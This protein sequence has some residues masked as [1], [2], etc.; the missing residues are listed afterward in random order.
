MKIIIGTRGSQLAL[1]QANYTKDIL[2][3][4]GLE[5]EIK[6]ISTEGDRSQEWN[7]RFDKLDGKGFFTKELEDALIGEQVDL[8]V[9]SFKDLPTEM[10]ANL[11]IGG[12]SHRANPSET[13]LIR[14]EFYDEKQVLKI[15]H[16]AIIGTSSARRKSQLMAYRPDLIIKDLRGNVPTRIKKLLEGEYDAILLAA[17]GLERLKPDIG[18]LMRFTL[19]PSEFIPAAAQGA[20]A[21]QC[22]KEHKE[23][24][25]HLNEMSH[26]ETRAEVEMERDILSAFGGGCQEPLGIYCKGDSDADDKRIFK[27]FISKAETWNAAPLQLYF[28]TYHLEDFARQIAESVRGIK[29]Q[30]VFIS[31]SFRE[32][33]YLPRSLEHLGFLFVASSLIEF[34]QIDIKVVPVSDWIFFTSKH[35]VKYFLKQ[36][37]KLWDVKFGCISKQTAFAL[38][39]F[40][41]SS[42]FIGQG[43][44]TKI[45]GKQFSSMAGRS[46]V[47]FPVAKESMNSVQQQILKQEQVINLPVYE[48]IKHPKKVD[49]DTAILVFT[50]PSNVLAYLE[51]N[52]VQSVQKAVAMGEATANALRKGG[53][54]KIVTTDTFDDLGLL[55]AILR[56]SAAQWTGK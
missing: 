30:K 3:K 15:R 29:A 42:A 54:K 41:Y 44:D 19:P 6:V 10:H 9:H 32:K 17:A 51:L 38:R 34:R 47:L 50:S 11:V 52:K 37:P 20:L 49:A 43:I 12:V 13:I 24:L 8:A 21:W 35:S 40:G 1:F 33:D 14:P 45:I 26:T 28:E 27:I 56:Q 39:Q 36:K 55:R 2:E 16:G 53:F 46:K 25:G 5:V 22:R 4:R 18:N 31:K 7:T 48:T 23:L